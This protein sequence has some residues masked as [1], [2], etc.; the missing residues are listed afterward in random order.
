MAQ[1]D[2]SVTQVEQSAK[3]TA[4]I[5]EAVRA[6]VE[7][8][9]SSVEA[10]ISGILEIR[11]SSQI[12]A[13][14]I[15]ALSDKTRNIGAI[16]A[17]IDEVTDQTSLLALN[18]AI[19]AAQA[20]EHGSGFAVVAEEIRELSKRASS[21]TREISTV[22]NDVQQETEKVVQVIRQVEK[23]VAE[24]E[25]LSTQSGEAL[26]KIV[27]GIREVDQRMEQIAAATLEQAQG[28]RMI[29]STM[30]K[31]SQ[32]IDQ[33]AAASREQSTAAGNI[34]NAVERMKEVTT[35]VKTSTRE[36]SNGSKVI[37]GAMEEIN[38][39]VQKIHTACDEQVRESDH[40]KTAVQEISQSADGN[41]ESTRVLKESV[42]RQNQQ[43]AM[44]QQEMAAFRVSAVS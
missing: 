32:M 19:I 20:G 36:Q 3:E 16:L 22:I 15:G 21:S 26:D 12:T 41:L 39:M 6:D 13:K 30:E 40:I 14:A 23:S 31:V 38:G 35:H 11:N 24:G 33:T 29:R 8:G 9:R 25:R 28:S 17:M 7:S 44:L 4:K 43:I 27:N 42:S 1:M 34:M 37:S 18:A 5:T 2:S 10:T